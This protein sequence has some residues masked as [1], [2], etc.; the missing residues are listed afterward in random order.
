MKKV[1][2]SLL[3]FTGVFCSIKVT[4][5]TEIKVEDVAKHIGD[6]VKII[7]TI[8]GGRYF[9][10]S[11]GTPTLLNAGAAYPKSPLTLYISAAV[12]NK[13]ATAPEEMYKGK[14]VIIFGKIIMFKDKPEI[15][16]YGVAQILLGR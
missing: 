14:T 7:T 2:V 15:V 1:L 4:A 12:R 5:Q 9:D 11:Q 13:F 10:Q 3:C 6:S 8:Y 16:V